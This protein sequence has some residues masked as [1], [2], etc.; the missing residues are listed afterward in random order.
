MPQE[1]ASLQLVGKTGRLSAGSQWRPRGAG[2]WLLIVVAC[3]LTVL[4]AGLAYCM[5]RPVRWDGPG[6]FGGAA[7]FFPLH[8]LAFTL[9]A[10]VLALLAKRAGARLA[11][12]VI[13]P[14]GD[15]DGGD[16]ADADHHRMATGATAGR[17][18]LVGQLPRE[19]R[20]TELWPPSAG[21]QRG[22]WDGDGRHAAAAGRVAHRQTQH[23]PIRRGY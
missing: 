1:P 4:M 19:R 3:L 10:A 8:L 15:P 23:R 6:K 12:W 17:A 21:A 7:L 22:L 20:A 14:G 9:F 5:V 2:A 13:R 18:A 16:G 11:A